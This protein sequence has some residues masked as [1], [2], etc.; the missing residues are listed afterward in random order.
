MK[1]IVKL[2]IIMLLVVICCSGV[3]Q[4][5]PG[6][7]I[8]LEVSNSEFNKND[9]FSVDVKMSNIVSE[10][11]IIALEAIL[12][13]DKDSLTLIEIKG[14][15][16]W[17]SAVKDLS[18]N[19]ETG[20]LVIDKDGLAKSDEVILKISFQVKENSKKNLMITLKNIKISDT[21]VPATIKNAYKNITI[22]GGEEN[23]VP[24]PPAEENPDVKPDPT[25]DQTQNTTPGQTTNP[26]P[27]KNTNKTS[28]NNNTTQKENMAKGIIPHAGIGSKILI[29]MVVVAIV[30]A[31]V[32]YMKI[33]KVNK[34]VNR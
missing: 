20:K 7:D 29:V 31:I 12:E 15:N 1:K 33:K 9:T 30:G 10:K 14:Q 4:A 25:P 18:Y 32:F 23:P 2:S 17:S 28:N 11:G 27:D 26:T 16:D 6:C 19:E 21:T 24:T 8:S 3:V 5:A 13:Y 22:T 34:Q